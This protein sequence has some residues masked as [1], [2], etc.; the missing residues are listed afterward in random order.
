MAKNLNNILEEQFD[1]MYYLHMNIADYN[2]NDARDNSWLHS[3]LCKQKQDEVEAKK[4]V[5]NARK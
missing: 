5:L 1:L 2:E 3:R 4:K